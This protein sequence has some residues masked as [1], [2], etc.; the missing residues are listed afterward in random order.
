MAVTSP[1]IQLN[2]NLSA[3]QTETSP[4]VLNGGTLAGDHSLL[5]V[6]EST[7]VLHAINQDPVFLYIALVCFIV[8]TIV[9]CVSLWRFSENR[10]QKF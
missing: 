5:I 9:L 4:I 7:G 3:I 6:D 8:F 1:S 2:E 10:L